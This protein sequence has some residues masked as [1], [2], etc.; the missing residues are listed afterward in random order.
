MGG[1]VPPLLLAYVVVS[2]DVKKEAAISVSLHYHF[3]DWAPAEL[4]DV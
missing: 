2:C 1:V 4:C 3:G